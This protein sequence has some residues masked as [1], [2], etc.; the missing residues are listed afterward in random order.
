[1]ACSDSRLNGESLRRVLQLYPEHRV[2][3]CVGVL[4]LHVQVGQGCAIGDVLRNGHSVLCLVEGGRLIVDI[5][6]C[7]GDI[8]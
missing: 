6:Y 2:G 8:C 7:N 5:P 1:M 3:A 4:D